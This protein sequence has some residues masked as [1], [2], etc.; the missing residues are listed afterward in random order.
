MS[1]SDAN[2]QNVVVA[3]IQ[4]TRTGGVLPR[5]SGLAP[6]KSYDT[7]MGKVKEMLTVQEWVQKVDEAKAQAQW[8]E[9][10]AA[11]NAKPCIVD[12]TPAAN[13][14][15]LAAKDI[16]I[17]VWSEFKSSILQQFHRKAGVTELVNLQKGIALGRDEIVS[18]FL[19]RVRVAWSKLSDE[20]EPPASLAT[21]DAALLADRKACAAAFSEHMVR[22]YLLAGLSEEMLNTVTRAGASEIAEILKVAEDYEKSKTQAHKL[23]VAAVEVELSQQ[24]HDLQAQV[25]ALQGTKGA[26]SGTAAGAGNRRS[27]R[28]P[29]CY[30]CLK[31]GH[32]STRCTDRAAAEAEGKYRPTVRDAFMTKEAYDRLPRHEKQKGKD[33]IQAQLAGRTA[34]APRPQETAAAAAHAAPWGQAVG[35]SF[36]D[37]FSTYAKN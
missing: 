27:K 31:E 11:A 14:L 25:A 30:Y 5:Y 6:G 9:E 23:P 35:Q 4:P 7:P 33:I 28:K 15:V 24:V 34:Q 13:W 20:Y 3:A 32:I 19:M 10:V 29:W 21:T 36:E 22:C 2:A 1:L 17:Q 37:R 8:S 26:N 12:H 16:N 18:D